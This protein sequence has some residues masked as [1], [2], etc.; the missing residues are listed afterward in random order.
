VPAFILKPL[1]MAAVDM[2]HHPRQRTTLTALTMHTAFRL[3]FRRA[4]TLQRLLH[5]RVTQLDPV[6]LGQLLAKMAHVQVEILFSI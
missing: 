5:P 4:G 3:P 2:Q 6:L 1:V